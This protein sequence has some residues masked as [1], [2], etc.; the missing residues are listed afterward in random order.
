MKDDDPEGY[1]PRRKGLGLTG[2]VS[3]AYVE[4]QRK[5]REERPRSPLMS[6]SAITGLGCLHI[7]EEESDKGSLLVNGSRV[8]HLN[9]SA[10]FYLRHLF[11]GEDDD[12]IVRR[13]TKTFKV[14]KAIA[15][16]DLAALKADIERLERGSTPLRGTRAEPLSGP[17]VAPMRMDLSLTYRSTALGEDLKEAQL[18]RELTVDEWLKALENIWNFGVPHV[19][20]TGGEPTLREELVE[21]VERASMLGM[22]V[23]LLTDG[24][25]LGS[26]AFLGRLADAGLSYVQVSIASNIE[27]IHEKALHTPGHRKTVNAIRNCIKAGMPLLVNIFATKET[28]QGI[29]DTVESLLGLGVTNITVNPLDLGDQSMPDWAV[30][31]CLE[32]ARKA[33]RGKA[34][35]FYYGP[36]P[37]KAPPKAVPGEADSTADLALGELEW[38]AGLVH[39]HVHPDGSV[40]AGRGHGAILGNVLTHSWNMIWYHSL[41][42]DAREKQVEG[43]RWRALQE[44]GFN[45]YPLFPGLNVVCETVGE[46]P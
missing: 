2:H 13:V 1:Q 39:M 10:M 24:E 19:A 21:I 41:L 44:L 38:G 45:G 9:P 32:Q 15:R 7:R 18:G 33:A 30:A 5:K 37:G 6:R 29:E 25:R 4:H 34:R 16:Q 26:S 31:K 3:K 17:M 8:V 14:S 20:L 42:K 12:H 46:R 35:V 40:T 22:M 36:Y 43:R 23:G 27:A 11:A 28:E